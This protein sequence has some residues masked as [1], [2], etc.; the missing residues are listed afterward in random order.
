[1]AKTLIHEFELR[2]LY[3]TPGSGTDTKIIEVCALAKLYRNG[4][5]HFQQNNILKY[6]DILFGIALST[7]DEP[8]LRI[9][10]CHALC[11]CKSPSPYLKT[12][13][14]T[15]SGGTWIRSPLAQNCL[16]DLLRRTQTENGWPWTFVVQ[17]L[18]SDWSHTTT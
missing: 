2:G 14:N 5:T 7:D 13:A 4:V 18:S 3:M 9:M 16:L 6:L 17:K 15:D 10:A 11:A 12:D 8:S 1:M